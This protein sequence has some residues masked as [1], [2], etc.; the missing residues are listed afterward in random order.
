M[1]KKLI[2]DA[3]SRSFGEQDV[4]PGLSSG[5]ALPVA[6]LQRL[7]TRQPASAADVGVD[8]NGTAQMQREAGNLGGVPANYHLAG[9]VAGSVF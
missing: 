9:I 8:A 6:V 3:D 1:V 2:C 7:I 4:H 5:I